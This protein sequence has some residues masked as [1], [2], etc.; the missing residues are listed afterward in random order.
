MANAIST[1]RQEQ[2][3]GVCVFVVGRGPTSGWS[4]IGCIRPGIKTNSPSMTTHGEGAE[5]R[6]AFFLP[7][8]SSTYFISW[9]FCDRAIHSL[10]FLS[11]T[12]YAH[13]LFLS[14]F[15]YTYTHR[16]TQTCYITGWEFISP[17][18]WK[19]KATT[20]RSRSL[21]STGCPLW[22]HSSEA[23]HANLG[24]EYTQSCDT[25]RELYPQTLYLFFLNEQR[26]GWVFWAWRRQDICLG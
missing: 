25:H 11:D 3:W 18:E 2:G 15:T 26:G 8:P 7:P 6:D 19:K 9:P 16:P 22:L 10:P 20:L 21:M 24:P 5:R 23:P 17:S 14:S 12:H 4:F 13:A 1:G